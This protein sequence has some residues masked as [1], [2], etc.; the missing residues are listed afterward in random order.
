MKNPRF[1]LTSVL[2]VAVL[3]SCGEADADSRLAPTRTR[4]I[5]VAGL[6]SSPERLKPN[7]EGVREES[8]GSLDDD[9]IASWCF[10]EAA[11]RAAQG[12]KS[13][14]A[15]SRE[16]VEARLKACEKRGVSLLEHQVVNARITVALMHVDRDVPAP[17]EKLAD[18][19]LVKRQRAVIDTAR[20]R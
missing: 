13:A 4:A 15:A 16:M 14:Y 9:D 11:G 5:P 20:G 12:A 18:V 2:L 3:I 19:A 10:V 8:R 17:E 7:G 1:R 6:P